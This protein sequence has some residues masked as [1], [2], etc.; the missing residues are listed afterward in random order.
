MT[1]DE[2]DREPDRQDSAA[3]A[4]R[5][6]P[7]EGSPLE[8]E[9]RL[10]GAERLPGTGREHGTQEGLLSMQ[11]LR[12]LHHARRLSR[13]VRNSLY[14]MID[15]RISH[16]LEAEWPVLSDSYPEYATRI[17]EAVCDESS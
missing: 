2:P 8:S 17:R 7:A 4:V 1:D 5:E 6:P 12:R 15:A 14:A 11:E 16:F 10:Y 3:G 13:P 9:R